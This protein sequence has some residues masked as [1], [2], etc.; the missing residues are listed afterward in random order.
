VALAKKLGKATYVL[1][2]DSETSK[3]AHA[4]YVPDGMRKK[5]LDART[6]AAKVAEVIGGKVSSDSPTKRSTQGSFQTGGKEDG[7]Q[8]SGTNVDKVE[9]GLKAAQAYFEEEI[10]KMN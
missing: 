1:S 2:V 9:Q 8:G 4:N 6:W 5:G 3:V 10:K 7:A